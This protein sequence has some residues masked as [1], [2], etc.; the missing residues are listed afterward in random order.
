MSDFKAK[1]NQI[2][3]WGSLQYFP[4]S[5]A[6][7]KRPT[8]KGREGKGREELDGREEGSK[9]VMG[10]EGERM[11]EW[12]GR[13]NGREKRGSE[14]RKGKAWRSV[15]TNKNLQ[16]YCCLEGLLNPARCLG[17]HCKLPSRAQGGAPATNTFLAYFKYISK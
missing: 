15:P 2:R 3:C 16:L 6:R 1:M 5:L 4:D 17:E 7:F 8:S 9:G 13:E 11:E 12:E 10:K 14:E